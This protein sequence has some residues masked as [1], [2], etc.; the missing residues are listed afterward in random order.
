M[1]NCLDVTFYYATPYKDEARHF[2][3]ISP[4]MFYHLRE[5]FFKTYGNHLNEIEVFFHGTMKRFEPFCWYPEEDEEYNN[6][7]AFYERYGW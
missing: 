5:K 6:P 4:E 7:T 3:N 1:R 2:K